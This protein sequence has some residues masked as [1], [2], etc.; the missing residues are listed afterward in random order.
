MTKQSLVVVGMKERVEIAV[1]FF[2]WPRNDMGI[3]EKTPYFLGI[4]LYDISVII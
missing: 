3:E 4:A 2:E 1:A